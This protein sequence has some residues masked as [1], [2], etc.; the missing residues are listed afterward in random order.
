MSG[1]AMSISTN[2]TKT[3]GL[4]KSSSSVPKCNYINY[5]ILHCLRI[6]ISFVPKKVFLPIS[7]RSRA[8]CMSLRTPCQKE[9]SGDAYRSKQLISLMTTNTNNR[10]KYQ[11]SSN[12]F[13]KNT[14]EIS[15]EIITD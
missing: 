9:Q 11:K 3:P 2:Q 6:L 15:D 4:S 10:L 12:F 5:I 14:L 1:L 7:G 13:Q 8:P